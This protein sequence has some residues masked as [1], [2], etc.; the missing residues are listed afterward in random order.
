LR[1]ET[2]ISAGS[3][4]L[5]GKVDRI[6]IGKNNFTIIDYKSGTTVARLKEIELGMSLQLPVYLYAVER[7]LAETLNRNLNGVAGIYYTLKSP[8]KDQVGVGSSEH[9]GTAFPTTRKSKQIFES[10]ADLRTIINQ[11]IQFVN[12]YVDGIAM[13]KFPV[14]PKMP[15][16]ICAYCD[17][18]TICRIQVSISIEKEHAE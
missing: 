10:D 1:H 5:R 9:L 17:F 8:V 18:Q 2:H 11:A 15:E 6:E 13:G 14:E 7:I 12:D 4:K 16:K 3:V